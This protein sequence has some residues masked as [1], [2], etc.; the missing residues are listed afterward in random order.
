MNKMIIKWY[1]KVMLGETLDNSE[2]I[3]AFSFNSPDCF[4]LYA[5]ANRIRDYYK[6][7]KIKLCGIINAKSGRCSEDCIFCSQ[8]IH[9]NTNIEEYALKSKEEI[10]KNASAAKQT[11]AHSFGIV[12]S[13]KGIL[14]ESEIQLITETI[15]DIGE[16][17]G[18]N[19]CTALGIIDKEQI[20]KLKKAGISSYNIN[21]ECSEKFF[22]KICTTHD[23]T[24]KVKTIEMLK[25]EGLDICCGG[26]FGL[27]ESPEDRLDLA[28][29][30]K[31]LKIESVNINFLF[32]ITGTPAEKFNNLSPIECLNIISVYRFLLPKA[33]IR[34]CGG[35]E[36]NLKYLQ[37]LMYIAGANATMIGNYLTTA[38]RPASEDLDIIRDLNLSAD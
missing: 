32:S 14:N 16:K 7:N 18:L 34:I 12:T 23:Y 33:D 24:D 31:S 36:K 5:A 4:E 17:V 38:G 9:Y 35:R 8:S 29:T 21:L 6:G 22:P 37:P 26:I 2:I 30:L 13:G 27:G 19:V 11:G 20:C 25:E 10:L 1:E 28:L 3:N 15:K